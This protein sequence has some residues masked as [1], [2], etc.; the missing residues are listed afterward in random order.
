MFSHNE[1]N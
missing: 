1:A